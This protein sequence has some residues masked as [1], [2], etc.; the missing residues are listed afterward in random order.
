MISRVIGNIESCAVLAILREK[1]EKQPR[2]GAGS[3]N[4]LVVYTMGNCIEISSEFTA[5]Y[6]Y[7]FMRLYTIEKSVDFIFRI[8]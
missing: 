7:L 3:C 4:L 8:R 1:K 2:L 6:V 5:E